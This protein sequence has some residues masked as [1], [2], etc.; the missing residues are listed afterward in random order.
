MKLCTSL[1]ALFLPVIICDQVYGTTFTFSEWDGMYAQAVVTNPTDDMNGIES[2]F[3]CA[4][5]ECS[6]AQ[7]L[8]VI[9][10]NGQRVNGGGTNTVWRKWG[11]RGSQEIISALQNSYYTQSMSA[12]FPPSVSPKDVKMICFEAKVV[13]NPGSQ[14]SNTFADTCKSGGGTVPPIPG[15]SWCETAEGIDL[16]HGILRVGDI[17]GHR[18]EQRIVYTCNDTIPGVLSITQSDLLLSGPGKNVQ[19]RVLINDKSTLQTTMT[20]GTNTFSLSS[21]LKL[22]DD[23]KPGVYMGSTVLLW[24][25]D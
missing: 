2:G 8:Y 18:I 4:Y 15:Q 14:Y 17:H 5:T 21:T 24:T 16:S 23:I 19:S 9:R 11:A 7:R 13:R 6:Y 12:Y 22:S 10:K 3:D 25:P 20:E 1:I